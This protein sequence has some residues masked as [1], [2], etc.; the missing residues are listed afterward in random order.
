[1]GINRGSVGQCNSGLVR[2]WGS[3]TAQG[4]LT[5]GAMGIKRGWVR[6]C[7]SGMVRWLGSLT[8]EG[9][10]TSVLWGEGYQ[11]GWQSAVEVMLPGDQRLAHCGG[12]NRE[13]GGLPCHLV[14]ERLQGHG[15]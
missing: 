9:R 4:R 10:P 3:Q 12:V 11:L 14:S 13:H 1:M 6:Q 7:G 8:A 15:V 5:S 2:W